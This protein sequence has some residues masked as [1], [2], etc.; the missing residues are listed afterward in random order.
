MFE[1]KRMAPCLDS[2]IKFQ[3]QNL[4]DQLANFIIKDFKGSNLF[5]IFNPKERNGISIVSSCENKRFNPSQPTN[6]AAFNA[7]LSDSY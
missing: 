4:F 7:Y 1:V 3:T 2:Y 5:T 6:I